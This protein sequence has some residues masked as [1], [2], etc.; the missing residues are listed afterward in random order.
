MVEWHF[1]QA[2]TPPFLIFYTRPVRS[3]HAPFPSPLSVNGGLFA[4]PPVS[5]LA[6][7][8]CLCVMDVTPPLLCPLV[9]ARVCVSIFTNAR[10]L[11]GGISCPAFISAV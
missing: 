2:A 3:G 1:K 8:A 5:R 4:T 10:R 11:S 7:R 6:A 9:S